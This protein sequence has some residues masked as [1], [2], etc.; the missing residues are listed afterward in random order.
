MFYI[1]SSEPSNEQR[2]RNAS[3]PIFAQEQSFDEP[4]DCDCG[5]CDCTDCDCEDCDCGDDCPCRFE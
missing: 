4:M 3:I 1:L 2:P 5:D